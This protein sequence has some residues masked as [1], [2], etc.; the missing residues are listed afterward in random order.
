MNCSPPQVPSQ[1]TFHGT[2]GVDKG[3]RI[4][5]RS[6]IASSTTQP[7]PAMIAMRWP[8]S[9]IFTSIYANSPIAPCETE[10]R[11]GRFRVPGSRSPGRTPGAADDATSLR[12]A[13]DATS[14]ASGE[15]VMEGRSDLMPEP[16]P[17]LHVPF[18]APPS[19]EHLYCTTAILC[20]F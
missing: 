13:H 16:G 18:A 3:S 12:L 15:H 14:P 11:S 4:F 8:A 5:L 6:W 2:R 17:T 7:Q 20:M 9:M 19:H 1:E 10:K